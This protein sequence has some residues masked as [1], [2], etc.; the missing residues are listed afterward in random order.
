[1]DL[2]SG[3]AEGRG[4]HSGTVFTSLSDTTRHDS[5]CSG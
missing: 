3:A 1:M 4:M 2:G 5:E